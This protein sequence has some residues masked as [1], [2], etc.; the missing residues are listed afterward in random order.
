MTEISRRCCAIVVAAGNSTR[1]EAR[2]PKIWIPLGGVPVIARTLLAFQRAQRVE[3]IVVVCRRDDLGPVARLAREH[4]L[5][6]VAK[7]VRG[8][9]TRQQS[10][11]RGIAAASPWASYFAVHDGARP[12]VRPQQI[13]EVIR[14]AYQYGA[15]A[16]AA[17]V[18]DTVKRADRR[19]MV[20]E[21]PPRRELWAV[22]TPQVFERFLYLHAMELAQGDYTD[23]C[24]LIENTGGTVHLCA[25]DSENLKLTTKEDI[26][27]AE[28]VL[29]KRRE[30][31]V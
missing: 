19:G 9:E 6:K 3:E 22:Q 17:P 10:V 12:L 25:G 28:A 27:F 4:S 15:S 24:Q 21:T 31:S 13:D 1:M 20:L 7:I 18:K 30:A 14:D 23:D 5:T 8:G 2:I 26:L 29:K 16:L 11:A